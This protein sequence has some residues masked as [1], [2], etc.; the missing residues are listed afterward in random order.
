MKKCASEKYLFIKSF[1][2]CVYV[3]LSRS[4]LQYPANHFFF[5]KQKSREM[6][7]DILDVNFK[8]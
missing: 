1:V 8:S 7:K 2:V 3:L 5:Y 6:L 4:F